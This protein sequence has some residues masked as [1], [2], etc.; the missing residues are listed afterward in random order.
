MCCLLS[1]EIGVPFLP[2]SSAETLKHILLE[3]RPD[4]DSNTNIAQPLQ[5]QTLSKT[6]W[7]FI[8]HDFWDAAERWCKR[9]L[10]QRALTHGPQSVVAQKEL[11]EVLHCCTSLHWGLWSTFLVL[12]SLFSELTHIVDQLCL[13]WLHQWLHQHCW[14]QLHSSLV[15][16]TSSPPLSELLLQNPHWIFGCCF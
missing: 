14:Q 13:W 5:K 4:V 15:A 2:L 9:G 16:D 12:C 11:L 1:A 3:S 10:A 8:P 7:I 6:T